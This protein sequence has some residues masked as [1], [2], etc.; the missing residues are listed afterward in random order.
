MNL[1]FYVHINISIIIVDKTFATSN[2]SI[3]IRQ[4]MKMYNY[5]LR[6]SYFKN[7][8]MITYFI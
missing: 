5:D 7:M 8:Y 1:I 4:K 2:L 6:K 3:Y